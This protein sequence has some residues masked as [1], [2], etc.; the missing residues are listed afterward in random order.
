MSY[1]IPEKQRKMMFC[2]YLLREKEE[3]GLKAYI[4]W[5]FHAH[6]EVMLSA[7]GL[8]QG[9]PYVGDRTLNICYEDMASKD[10]NRSK[11][12]TETVLDFFHNGTKHKPWRGFEPDMTHDAG[13][14]ATSKDPD[15]RK[16][17]IKIIKRLDHKYYNGD[18]A[19][20]DSMLPC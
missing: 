7:W 19:W 9:L 11:A 13:G 20:L 16:R 3:K 4:E 12:T 10:M 2:N 14:H 17:L 6:Y 18:I 8:S 5:V 1:E 15:M